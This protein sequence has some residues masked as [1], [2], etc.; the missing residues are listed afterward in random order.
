MLRRIKQFLDKFSSSATGSF[1]TTTKYSSY[2]LFPM[3]S[4]SRVSSRRFLIAGVTLCMIFLCA[5]IAF[6]PESVLAQSTSNQIGVNYD[7]NDGLLSNQVESLLVV[8]GTIWFGTDDGISRFDGTWQS[9]DSRLEQENFPPGLVTVIARAGLDNDVWAATD[10]GYVARWN[11][12]ANRWNTLA[13]DGLRQG[14]GSHTIHALL[15]EESFLWIGSDSGLLKYNLETEELLPI[16]YTENGSMP[17]YAIIE[18]EGMLWIGSGDDIF[19]LPLGG[20]WTPIEDKLGGSIT[21]LVW[22]DDSE[23]DGA[24]CCLYVGTF[25]TLYRYSSAAGELW[26]SIPISDDEDMPLDVTSLSAGAQGSLWVTTKGR[27]AIN[28]ESPKDFNGLLDYNNTVPERR[29]DNIVNAAGLDLDGAVWFATPNGVTQFPDRILWADYSFLTAV[30]DDPISNSPDTITITGTEWSNFLSVGPQSPLNDNLDLLTTTTG[31]M[32][33]ATGGG[34]RKRYFTNERVERE[35]LYIGNGLTEE[36]EVGNQGHPN[37]LLLQNTTT[38]LAEDNSGIIWAGFFNAGLAAYRDDQWLRVSWILDSSSG[39]S[40]NLL[41][42][43]SINDLIATDDNR[44]WIGSYVPPNAPEMITSEPNCADPVPGNPSVSG[45]TYVDLNSLEQTDEGITAKLTILDVAAGLTVRSLALDGEQLWVATDCEVFA[46]QPDSKWLR[47]SAED[48]L[49]EPPPSSFDGFVSIAAKALEMMDTAQ[50]EPVDEL[51][52][53]WLAAKGGGLFHWDGSVWRNGDPD[54]DLAT[55]DLRTL[56]ADSATG[57]L[58]IG[59]GAGVTR[60]DGIT[61]ETFSREDGLI[62]ASVDAITRTPSG[63]YLFGGRGGDGGGLSLYNPTDR[64]PPWIRLGQI[65]VGP[66]VSY[67]ESSGARIDDA[68]FRDGLT[69]RVNEQSEV[70][71]YLE[72]GDLKTPRERIQVFYRVNARDTVAAPNEWLSYSG[73]FTWSADEI[74]EYELEFLARD[75]SFNYSSSTSVPI[76]VT[77]LG[78]FDLSWLGLGDRVERSTVLTLLFL[79]TI[80]LLAFGYVGTERFRQRQQAIEAVKR[81]Y[82]PYVSGEP[83]RDEDMFFG[84][85]G[86][87]QRIVDTL[88]NNSIMIHGER[89]IGKTT[90]LFQLGSTLEEVNDPEYWFVPIYIDLEGTSEEMFFHHLME[91][92]VHKLLGYENANSLLIPELD[93][94]SYHDMPAEAYTDRRFTRDLRTV[95]QTLIIYGETEYPNRK[96][97]VI[98]LMDEMDVLSR[99]DHLTQQQLRRIFMRDF[100]AN[101]GAIVAGIEISHKWDRVESPW[102]NLFNEIEIEPFGREEAIALLKEPVTDYYKYEPAAIEM[103][104]THSDGRPFRIQQYALE[105]VAH[106]LA[107]NRRLI[108]PKDVEAAHEN[109]QNNRSL[110]HTDSGLSNEI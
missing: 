105:S 99:Y 72:F 10:E 62:S 18:N 43:Q 68:M 51:N 87:L 91:E 53:I 73:P 39:A 29:L 104:L 78:T 26:K 15:Q 1:T 71:L 9:Y 55:T 19:S 27:G 13:M 61:W 101:L 16:Q 22:I 93:K 47:W 63:K 66:D 70:P 42:S 82:N 89:R 23:G 2:F 25:G 96:L 85:H 34:I 94:L 76:S 14:D 92:I 36:S 49:G 109:I 95:V 8:E 45:L 103:I 31:E 48:I 4:S 67:Q 59:S 97:R 6:I 5:V 21:S 56:F 80:A 60:Y 12:Q 30:L 44:L 54:K 102:Y 41:V 64:T 50:M 100:A 37:A 38:A 77:P 24:T 83:I 52:D 88:H 46:Q 90:L 110:G 32:W 28:I 35:T 106:M 69:L 79:S 74:G 65:A 7:K 107:D 33:I 11:A 86:L 40:R 75:Q 20:V 17:V 108:K 84:R 81:G 98:L 57:A 58:W 3:T